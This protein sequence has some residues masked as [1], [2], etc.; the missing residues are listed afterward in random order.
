LKVIILLGII[1]GKMKIQKNLHPSGEI[2]G[3]RRV[4]R[5]RSKATAPDT[6]MPARRYF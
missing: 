1:H 4:R 3:Q 2:L 5:K 6:E